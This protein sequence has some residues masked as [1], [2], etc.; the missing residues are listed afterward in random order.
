[1]KDDRW[2]KVGKMGIEFIC[3]SNA[4]LAFDFSAALTGTTGA[5]QQRLQLPHAMAPTV[6]MNLK[7]WMEKEAVLELMI[8]IF[9][10]LAF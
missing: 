2:S 9:E 5:Q 7:L 10:C 6:W 8:S 1:M 3:W 4:C